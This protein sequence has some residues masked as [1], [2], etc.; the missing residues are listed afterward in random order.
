MKTPRGPLPDFQ[1]SCENHRH[2]RSERCSSHSHPYLPASG[3]QGCTMLIEKRELF[4]DSPTT[5][6]GS[7]QLPGRG[8]RDNTEVS[9]RI[10]TP[11]TKERFHAGFRN[12][13]RIP[14]RPKHN[15]VEFYYAATGAC[16]VYI[17]LSRRRYA[18]S[19]TYGTRNR[20]NN[21]CCR[22]T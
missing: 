2:R 12:T 6:L 18:L 14:F 20:D 1:G 7:F 16:K 4:L 10:R 9:T 5:S 15:R 19:Y 11:N 17:K 8:T 21:E 22:V 13:N 3:F